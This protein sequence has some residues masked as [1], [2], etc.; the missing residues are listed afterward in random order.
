VTISVRKKQY[1]E[2]TFTEV[3]QAMT[4]MSAQMEKA[5]AGLPGGLR[6]KMMS[7][8]TREA[9]LTKGE[10]RNIAGLPCQNYIVTLGEK[11]RMETCATTAIK[12]PFDPKNFR[13]LALATAPITPGSSP[14]NRMVETMRA[15]EGISIASS[16]FLSMLGKTIETTMEA[17]EIRKGP[18]GASTFDIPQDFK[19]VDSPWH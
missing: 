12:P 14:V 13:K 15:I 6:E 17:A 16:T 4:S 1:S 5:M 3:E 2:T 9:T 8:A 10:A 11:N 19:K 7:D 18:I